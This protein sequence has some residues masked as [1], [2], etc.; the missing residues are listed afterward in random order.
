M[1]F[2]AFC[3]KAFCFKALCFKALGCPKAVSCKQRTRFEA[4]DLMHALTGISEVNGKAHP[5]DLSALEL[6]GFEKEFHE[7]GMRDQ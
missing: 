4:L 2:K 7:C 1:G 5:V 6:P 3:P